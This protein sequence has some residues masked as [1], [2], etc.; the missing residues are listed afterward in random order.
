MMELVKTYK[1]I[2]MNNKDL[3]LVT[4]LNMTRNGISCHYVRNESQCT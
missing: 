4:S 1:S 2:V 3:V